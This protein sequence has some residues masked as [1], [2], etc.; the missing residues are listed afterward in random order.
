MK[1]IAVLIVVLVVAVAALWFVA[2]K[3]TAPKPA[4]QGN[5]VFCAADVKQCPDGSYVSRIPPS[6]GFNA[7]PGASSTVPIISTDLDSSDSGGT[8]TY[9]VT[10]RFEIFL[11][12][13]KYPQS[14]LKVDCNPA[15]AIGPISN[16]PAAPKGEYVV[17]YEGVQPGSCTISDRGFSIKVVIQ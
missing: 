1:K 14:E 15:N 17:R 3:A 8:F 2:K 10:S 9:A 4:Y 16:I 7:C 13:S 5:L 12:M 11:D 6:C